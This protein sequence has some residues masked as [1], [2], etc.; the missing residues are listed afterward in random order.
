LAVC[1]LFSISG[2][3]GLVVFV[4]TSQTFMP[5]SGR[6]QVFG[7]QMQFSKQNMFS[8]NGCWL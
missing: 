5:C 2:D 8:W 6:L 1:A 4:C 7:F 3:A